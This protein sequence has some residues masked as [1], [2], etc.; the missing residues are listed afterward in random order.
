MIVDYKKSFK[1]KMWLSLTKIFKR[2]ANKY[3]QLYKNS[4]FFMK[5]Q[6]KNKKS[7]KKI[8]KI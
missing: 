5:I 4:L 2:K 1:Y 6:K 8:K 3:K 7:R